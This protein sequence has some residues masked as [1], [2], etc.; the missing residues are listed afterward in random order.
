MKNLL[1]EQI[2]NQRELL[3]KNEH[4]LKSDKIFKL[5]KKKKIFIFSKKICL[6]VDKGKEVT[7]KT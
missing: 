6:Y 2:L 5:L 4:R 7:T 1:R 3:D